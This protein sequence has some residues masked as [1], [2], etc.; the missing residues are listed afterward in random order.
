MKTETPGIEK[1]KSKMK[2]KTKRII[3]IV[4]VVVLAGGGTAAYFLTN[5]AKTGAA[6][7]QQLISTVKTGDI[8]KVIEASG[9][10]ESA[11]RK[12]VAPKVTSTIETIAFAEGDEVKKGDVMFTLDDTDALL[13]IEEIN[14]SI[15]TTQVS[16]TD[17]QESI[18]SLK[19]VAPFSGQ[20]TNVSLE[21][22]DSVNNGGTILTIT[23]T[24]K[25]KLTVPFSGSGVTSINVGHSAMVYLPGLMSAVEGTVSYI[26]KT[27][28][29]AANGN[30]LYTV[31]ITVE[32]PGSLIADTSASAEIT[33]ASGTLSSTESGKLE[34]INSK[35][36]RND[37]GGTVDS[38]KVKEKQYVN[39]GD[40][41]VTLSNESLETSLSTTELK[42]KS[43]QSQLEI[44]NE[45][46]SYYTI[47]APC[48]G[49]II[50]QEVSLG[51][52]V[53]QGTTVAVVSDMNDLQFEVSIDELDIANIA[54]DQT[55][56]ITA[57]AV[58]ST[59]TTPL[60]GKVKKIYTEGTSSNGVTVYPVIISVDSNDLLKIGM[61]VN[62][63]IAI[64]SKENVLIV[65][66]EA[67]ATNDDGTSYVYVKTDSTSANTA[68]NSSSATASSGTAASGTATAGTTA[69]GNDTSSG[70]APQGGMTP[71]SGAPNG[72]PPS[73]GVMP[74]G[75]P[76]A[77]MTQGS[78]ASGS[79]TGS[80]SVS[81][82]D[83]YAGTE[84]VTV[85]T[86]V[87]DDTN[88]EITSGLTEGQIVVLPQNTTNSTEE[89]TT[90]SSEQQGGMMGG[91][92]S[93]GGNMGGPPG[94]F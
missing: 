53:T 78:A 27:P 8:S 72:G 34:Y 35:V 45:Q 75:A 43:L 93:G 65:P 73:G 1:K 22:G 26:S 69:A 6:G 86:G 87:N 84:K 55:V 80:V 83:Y 46:L 13:S 3:A 11:T 92:P 50:T 64:S 32:N 51:D 30:Q 4:L 70:S 24:S 74:S 14:N 89:E 39:K 76:P 23:D 60:T 71:P 19:V 12:T 58:E 91:M 94:G 10:I 63:T 67:V 62:G 7:I 52:T 18:A 56:S 48:D 20:V 31:E 15:A 77:N 57:D 5:A 37:S 90:T 44:K 41:L 21:E 38:V 82:N 85:T 29:M 49:T 88:I 59:T 68:G 42:L 79:S 36:I 17:T 81:G 9:P 61:N 28:Y 16:L 2:K 66:I 40:V 25:L 47:T 54:V 33:T